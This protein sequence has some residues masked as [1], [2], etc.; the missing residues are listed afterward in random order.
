MISNDTIQRLYNTY[1]E[2]PA[3]FE[4]RGLNRLMEYAF[5]SDAVDFDGDRI[6]FN[7][8]ARNSPLRSIELERIYGVEELENWLAVVLPAA[9]LFVNRTDNAVRVHLKELP[10]AV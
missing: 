7:S 6:V 2:A 10:E 4:N 3:L 9:I 1:N 8:V 5:D